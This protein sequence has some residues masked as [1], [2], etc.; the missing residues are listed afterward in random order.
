MYVHPFT[1][2]KKK[3]KYLHRTRGNSSR[4]RMYFNFCP[5]ERKQVLHTLFKSL[6]AGKLHLLSEI[7]PFSASEA[8]VV[9]VS[10]LPVLFPPALCGH[11]CAQR[12]PDI[13]SRWSK[14]HRT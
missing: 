4:P 7:L 12:N 13:V 11:R 1:P 5:D 14:K 10:V 8:Q 6:L 3:K 2:K 9:Q